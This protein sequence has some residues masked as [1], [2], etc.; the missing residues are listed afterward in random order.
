MVALSEDFFLTFL[1]Q[2][3]AFKT[4]KPEYLSV[5]TVKSFEN[6]LEIIQNEKFDF[7][8]NI[9]NH[10]HKLVQEE[11][12]ERL[13][14]VVR[15]APRK[16]AEYHD[17][18][19]VQ[20]IDEFQFLSRY[21]YM[22]KYRERQTEDF[23]G[24]YLHTCEYKNAPM[25]VSGSWVGWLMDD[26]NRL[27]P[28]RFM[29][30]PMSALPD[31]EAVEMTLNYSII[32]NIPVTEDTTLL[33]AELTEGNPFYISELMRSLYDCKDLTTE[34]GVRKTLEFET[35]DL[36]G[37]IN[38]SWM[39]YIDAA[40]P[41]INEKHAKEI[42]LYLSKH[43]D[44]RVG[45][46]EL[47]KKLNI[48]MSDPELEKKLKALYRSDIIEEDWGCYRG[49]RDNIFD[50]VFRRAYSDD[51][52]HFVTKEATNE[53][54]ALFES[55]RKKYKS[56]SGEFNRYKGAYAE[57]MI[58]WHLKF[59]AFKDNIYFKSMM[60]NLPQDFEFTEYERVLSFTSPSLYQLEFQIDIFAR[61][62][63]DKYS[64]IGE[65][66][67]RKA[68]FTVKEATEFFEK[69]EALKKLEHVGPCILFVFSLS[70]FHKNT[71][72]FMKDKGFTWSEDKQWVKQNQA[73]L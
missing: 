50:K 28:G 58:S 2:Y 24:T 37:Q 5:N 49:V 51:I 38:S 69:A 20:M 47:K 41:K 25:L 40:F 13:W 15:D 12:M 65:V 59:D 72:R 64:I 68:K 73:G 70:G 17:E 52:H 35:L 22:D 3:V 8:V 66:K 9:T 45:H 71:L 54:K 67:Y 34:Q 18:R 53:Y 7:L 56:L 11:N 57:F 16:I 61:A 23:I 1:Y 44:R 10:V 43:R 29:K 30:M 39:E 31:D 36:D 63:K 27:L 4:R 32:E 6:A 42:V 62:P 33:I 46:S 21:I 19:V 26:L 48:D 60:N 55:I 14:D